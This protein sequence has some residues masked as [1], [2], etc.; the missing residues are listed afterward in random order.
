MQR[1]GDVRHT[2]D[3]DGGTVKRAE[4]SAIMCGGREFIK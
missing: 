2:Q 1:R 3:A 4:R